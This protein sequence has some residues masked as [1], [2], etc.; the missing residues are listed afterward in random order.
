MGLCSCTRSDPDHFHSFT[1][2]AREE[3]AEVWFVSPFEGK[4]DRA[5]LEM[6]GVGMVDRDG[7]AEKKERKEAR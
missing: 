1:R 7:E 6:I 5:H 4:G 2:S 3:R